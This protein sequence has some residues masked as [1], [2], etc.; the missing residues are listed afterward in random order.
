MKKSVKFIKISLLLNL[1]LINNI[2]ATEKFNPKSLEIVEKAIVTIE[3]RI[4]VSAYREPGSWQ[5]TG[6]INDKESG[7]IVTNNHVVG[8]ASIGTYFVTFH[9]GRQVQAKP[10]YYDLWQDYAILKVDPKDI[11]KSIEQIS[12]SKTPVRTGQSVFVI[13]SPEGHE[14]SYHTGYISNIYEINGMMPQSSY[15]INL[16][17]AGGA[18]GSPLLNEKNE[19]IGVVYGGSKTYALALHGEYVQN[20]LDYIKKGLAPSRKHIGVLC[21]QYSLDKAVRHRNFSQQEMDNFIKQYPQA[22]NKAISIKSV[23]AGSPAEGVILVGDIIWEVENIPLGGNLAILDN[24]MD[25]STNEEIKLT[26]FRNGKKLQQSIK[27]YNINNNKVERIVNFAGA[28]FFQ[29]DD[30]F[31]TKTGIPLNSLA[32]NNVQTG[33]SFSSIPVSFRQDYKSLY[34]LKINSINE[35]V[36]TNLDQLIKIIPDAVKQKFINVRFKNFQPYYPPFDTDSTFV[37]AQEELVSDITFDSID[38]KPRI[39]K[40]DTQSTE[41][42]SEDIESIIADKI[43]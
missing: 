4:A 24:N 6:F 36:A 1:V 38:T 21:E 43:N 10:I 41:W 39:L 32:L 2:F 8:G 12:F 7:L 14:F 37:S 42:I 11:P 35:Q 13:G 40:F 3:S 28:T 29:A 34:R 18:S 15:I 25:K 20:A 23:I 27:L 9:N 30:Y 31:S 33:S 19:A 16:N 5:G 17:S 26:I 22:R